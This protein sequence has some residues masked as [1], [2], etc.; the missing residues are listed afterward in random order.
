[1]GSGRLHFSPNISA[2]NVFFAHSICSCRLWL[3]VLSGEAAHF[4]ESELCRYRQKC[5]SFKLHAKSESGHPGDG[6]DDDNVGI[7][8]LLG[9]LAVLRLKRL[10]E[11]GR[12][13]G[14]KG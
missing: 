1:M 12:L 4:R 5:R 7:D 13:A 11:A 2:I 8:G 3:C 9:V 6:A 10:P 14:G